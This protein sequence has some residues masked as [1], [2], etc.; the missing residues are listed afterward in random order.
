MLRVLDPCCGSRM[1]WHDRKHHET[2]YGDVRSETVTVPDRSHG[3]QDGKR[4]LCVQPDILMDFR[5]M[6]FSDGVFH[7]VVFDPPH[8]TRAGP[9]SWMAAKYGKL[10]SNWKEDLSRGFEECFRVLH[11]NGTL[12][13]KWSESQVK[14]KEVL[15]LSPH[16]PLFGQVNVRG[17][18]TH[19]LTFM[20]PA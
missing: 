9:K 12:I 16:D 19:W 5:N 20:H 13:F 14:L 18:A 2:V 8:L 1:M 3:K 11:K 4:V 6:P 15:S 17:G 7:L 10:S